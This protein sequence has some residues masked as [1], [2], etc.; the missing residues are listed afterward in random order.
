MKMIEVVSLTWFDKDTHPIA[1]TPYWIDPA[2]PAGRSKR[3]LAGAARQ[4]YSSDEP[5]PVP[6]SH[7]YSSCAASALRPMDRSG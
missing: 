4:Y 6:P 2:N 5:P 7:L 3:A 1:Y